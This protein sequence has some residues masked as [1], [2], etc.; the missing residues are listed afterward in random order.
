MG[1]SNK[2]VIMLAFGVLLSLLTVV[3][4]YASWKNARD[5]GAK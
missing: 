2:D 5:E 4:V 3:E 1:R